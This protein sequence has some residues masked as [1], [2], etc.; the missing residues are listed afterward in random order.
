[1]LVTLHLLVSVA[2]DD[3]ELSDDDTGSNSPAQS[4][5][6][7]RGNN[8]YHHYNLSNNLVTLYLLVS[9]AADDTELSDENTGNNS[10]AQS[11]LRIPQRSE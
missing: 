11:T 3:T 6:P 5:L 1:M 2:A 4:T 9:V 10:P 8:H 7:Q